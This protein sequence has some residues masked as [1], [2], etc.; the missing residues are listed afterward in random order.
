M[1]KLTLILALFFTIHLSA[2]NMSNMTIY[3]FSVPALEGGTI[4]F[5]DFKGKK[6]LIVN[7]ASECGYTPQYKQ[8]EEL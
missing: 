4:D 6:I 3:D 7:T 5:N 2:Q 1:Q 8:L